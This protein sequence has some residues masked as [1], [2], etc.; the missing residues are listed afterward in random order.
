MTLVTAAKNI[1]A[2]LIDTFVGAVIEAITMP[3]TVTLSVVKVGTV[4]AG[5]LM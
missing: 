5:S 3:V 4:F 2:F 1:I